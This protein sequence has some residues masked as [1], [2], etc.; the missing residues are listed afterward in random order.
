MPLV[1]EVGLGPGHIVLDGDPV[2]TQPPLQP[3]PTFG[4]CLLWRMWPNGRPSQQLLSYCYKCQDAGITELKLKG[5][6]PFPQE[7]GGGWWN[8]EVRR[9]FLLGVSLPV[10]WHYGLGDTKSI[11]H[12]KNLW[13]PLC[14]N[15]TSATMM[16]VIF[17]NA[18]QWL[19]AS[20][21]WMLTLHNFSLCFTVWHLSAVA[22]SVKLDLE[23]ETLTLLGQPWLVEEVIEICTTVGAPRI[24]SLCYQAGLWHF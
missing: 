9:W 6:T 17:I 1:K 8:G 13:G 15:T 2:G 19:F 3:L 18:K 21:I 11:R 7:S 23:T 22:M 20:Y 4:P 16:L 14:L 24:F 5:A 12:V 10:L